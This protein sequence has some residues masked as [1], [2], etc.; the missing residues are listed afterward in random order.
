MVSSLLSQSMGGVMMRW[1]LDP[2]EH[3]IDVI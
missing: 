3:V 2:N 1:I